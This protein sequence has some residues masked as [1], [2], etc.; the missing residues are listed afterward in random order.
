M[1]S[2]GDLQKAFFNA[3]RGTTSR[4]FASHA[5]MIGEK[6]PP[7]HN[8]P[9][10]RGRG[11]YLWLS[12]A[13]G[14]ARNGGTFTTSCARHGSGKLEASSLT[15]VD[16]PSRAVFEGLERIAER[17]RSGP[18]TGGHRARD[19][20]RDQYTDRARRRENR[21]ITTKGF[22]TCSRCGRERVTT[23]STSRSSFRRRSRRD[24]CASA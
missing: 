14:S 13:I 12:A 1:G 20:A 7:H 8:L 2:D 17:S 19:D 4:T 5:G 21:L 18:R 6:M 22:A 10:M 9:R 15:T 11:L 24:G 3:A 23:S 16:D